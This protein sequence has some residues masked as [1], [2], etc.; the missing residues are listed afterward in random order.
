MRQDVLISGLTT[1][2]NSKSV[3]EAVFQDVKV[4]TTQLDIWGLILGSKKI[5]FWKVNKLPRTCD[6]KVVGFGCAKAC[7]S[8]VR[9]SPASGSTSASLSFPLFISPEQF[10]TGA[11]WEV[12]LYL[13]DCHLENPSFSPVTFSHHFT[14]I[15]TSSIFTNYSVLAIIGTTVNS[16]LVTNNMLSMPLEIHWR[17]L[18]GCRR[19]SRARAMSNWVWLQEHD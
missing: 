11:H 14:I 17:A 8:Y 4:W 9:F 2:A 19:Q 5:Y 1:G 13:K 7:T 12:H 18:G 15:R 3:F 6:S 10:T 16:P